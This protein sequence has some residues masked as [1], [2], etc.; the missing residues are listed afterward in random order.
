MAFT[1]EDKQAM[2]TAASAAAD[3]L[4]VYTTQQIKPVATWLKKWYMMAGYKRLCR[5]LLRYA[6]E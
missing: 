5:I 3:E 2:D 6:E 1:E 4:E